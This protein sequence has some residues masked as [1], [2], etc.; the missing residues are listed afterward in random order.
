M[1]QL[2]LYFNK[3]FHQYYMTKV[4]M[5]TN[6]TISLRPKIFQLTSIG[7]SIEGYI[8]IAEAANYIP[9]EIKRVYWTYYTPQ[10]VIRGFHAHKVLHQAIFAV[11]GTIKFIVEELDGTREEYI[12]NEPHI[13][14]Y[15]P[16]Y[17]WREIQFSHNAVLLCLAS[18]H[19]DESDYI[20]KY[21]DFKS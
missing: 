11:C 1:P 4:Q 8:T 9:F 12:L 21:E 17:T 20:R 14:L 10:N 5:E 15:L 3:K 18:E 7:N 2:S 19:F 6:L 13:G 16:P